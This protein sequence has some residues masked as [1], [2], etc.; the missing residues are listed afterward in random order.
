VGERFVPGPEGAP[1]V[2]VLVYLPT[3]QAPL[4]ALLRIYGGY[5][6]G[7]A[8]QDDHAVKQIVPSGEEPGAIGKP[9]RCCTTRFDPLGT[10]S[11][12]CPPP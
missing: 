5:M 11:R 3:A 4:P 10:P 7:A 12:A 9:G 1:Q 6:I 8:E 2:P